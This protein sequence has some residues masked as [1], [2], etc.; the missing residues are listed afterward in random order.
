MVFRNNSQ[1]LRTLNLHFQY[2]QVN[3]SNGRAGTV[4]KHIK[5]SKL[6]D[7]NMKLHHAKPYDNYISLANICCIFDTLIIKQLNPSSQLYMNA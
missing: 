5:P 6:L 4:T 3:F 2:L 7:I 1:I